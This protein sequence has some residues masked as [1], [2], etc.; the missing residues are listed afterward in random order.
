PR[1][2]ALERFEDTFGFLADDEPARHLGDGPVRQDGLDARALIAAAH[3]VDLERRAHSTSLLRREIRV[4]PPP[5]ET[6]LLQLGTLVAR[7]LGQ[8]APDLGRQRRNAVLEA[9]D[10]H[11]P[12]LVVEAGDDASQRRYGVGDSAAVSARVE[13]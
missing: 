8:A 7:L 6:Q 2:V 4:A 11:S 3:A 12:V 13:V 10:D 5:V 1:D 9:L